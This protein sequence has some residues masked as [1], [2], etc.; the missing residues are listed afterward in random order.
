MRKIAVI[1][2]RAD[3][4]CARLNDGLVAVAIVLAIL[5]AAL[6]TVRNMEALALCDAEWPT[7]ET[8]D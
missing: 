3:S 1:A 8:K 5:T 2:A 6:S 4:F 7:A